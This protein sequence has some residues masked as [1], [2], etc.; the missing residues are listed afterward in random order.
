MHFFANRAGSE[1]G[2]VFSLVAPEAE[3]GADTVGGVVHGREAGPVSGPA[4][5]V[6][7]VRGF[8]ELKFTEFALIVE[9]LHKE[10]FTGVDDSFHHHIFQTGRCTEIDDG[11]AVLDRGGHGDGASDVFASLQSRDCLLGVVRDGGVDMNCINLG[12]GEEFLVAC[13]A[14]FDAIFVSNLIE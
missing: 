4:V 1:A 11:F 7:L 12:I 3:E 5:H 14:L 6:L 8:Q 2:H 9:L 13:V 10:E